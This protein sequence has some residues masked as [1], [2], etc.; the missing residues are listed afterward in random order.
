MTERVY[1]FKFIFAINFNMVNYALIGYGKMGKVI[2]TLAKDKIVSI[3]DPNV[4]AEGITH[5]SIDENS[6]KNVD[7]VIDFT[8]PTV[9]LSNVEKAASLGKNIV[10]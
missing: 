4:K 6:M 10:V 8:A 3:I 9:V 5:N 7:I 1:I 2:E